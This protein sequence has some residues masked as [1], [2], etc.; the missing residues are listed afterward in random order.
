MAGARGRKLD[1]S[2]FLQGNSAT[3]NLIAHAGDVEASGIAGAL[4]GVSKGIYTAG[5]NRREDKQR[6]EAKAEREKDRAYQRERAAFSDRLALKADARADADQGIQEAKF[7][8]ELEER[9]GDVAVNAGLVK[10]AAEYAARAQVSLQTGMPMD[11]KVLEGINKNAGAIQAAGGPQAILAE[12]AKQEEPDIDGLI[13]ETARGKA[14]H[15]I[16]VKKFSLEKNPAER[17]KLGDAIMLL[18]GKVA[19]GQSRIEL[20]DARL[21]MK[22]N[23]EEARQKGE[24]EAAE[25]AAKDDKDFADAREI[26]RAEGAFGRV[27]QINESGMPEVGEWGR[28]PTSLM[29]AKRML[30]RGKAEESS[31]RIETRQEKNAGRIDAR[32]EDQQSHALTMAQRREAAQKQ[33]QERAQAFVTQ[34]DALKAKGAKDD[35]LRTAM[36]DKLKDLKDTRDTAFRA[37]Q[38]L[39]DIDPDRATEWAAYMSARQLVENAKA[40]IGQKDSWQ[41]EPEYKAMTPEQRAEVD[42]KMAAAGK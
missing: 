18:T 17:V 7:Q 33:Q 35:D 12:A 1:L 4:G 25:A 6:A 32:Q 15:D 13:D 24:I 9:R 42:A 3:A 16:L 37:W 5:A 26:L 41:D 14:L 36:R 19:R 23:V 27:E 8:Q 20:H 22:A 39:L 29:D 28:E 2:G 38:K 40:S 34:R 11:P 10:Q 30:E 31:G 21:K